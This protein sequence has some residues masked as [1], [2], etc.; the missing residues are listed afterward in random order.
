MPIATCLRLLLNHGLEVTG[1]DQRVEK[2]QVVLV[3]VL[4][5]GQHL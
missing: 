1:V 3:G 4:R 5:M 2:V